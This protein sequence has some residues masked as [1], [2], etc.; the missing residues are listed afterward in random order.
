MAVAGIIIFYPILNNVNQRK[1]PVIYWLLSFPILSLTANILTALISTYHFHVF[2]IYFIIANI[3]IVPIMPLFILSGIFSLIFSWNGLTDILSAII[4]SIASMVST[5]PGATIS[6]LYPTVWY[7]IT[8]TIIIS[9]LGIAIYY[10]KRF[11]IYELV[12]LF[13]GVIAINMLLP[14]ETYPISEHY[15]IKHGKEQIIVERINNKC[16]IYTGQKSHAERQAI[17]EHFE[18]VLFDYMNLREIDSINVIYRGSSYYKPS[19][20]D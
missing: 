20:P 19:L 8:L 10:K 14:Q 3:L 1:Y 12:L 15:S 2:P 18:L 4:Q 11:L 6:A 9:L 16:S 5:F 7:V 17:K 13:F